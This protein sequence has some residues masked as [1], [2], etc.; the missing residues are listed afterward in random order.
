MGEVTT[1]VER[2]RKQEAEG[3]MDR[4]IEGGDKDKG[5]CVGA[6]VLTQAPF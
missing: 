3:R 6:R 5:M 1:E 2:G 4:G